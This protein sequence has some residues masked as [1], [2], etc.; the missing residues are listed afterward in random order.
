M[1]SQHSVQTQPQIPLSGK[2]PSKKE[3]NEVMKRFYQSVLKNFGHIR[4]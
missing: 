2:R 4:N 1:K 3:D